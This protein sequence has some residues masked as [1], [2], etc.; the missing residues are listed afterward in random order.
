M[1]KKLLAGVASLAFIASPAAAVNF[2]LGDGTDTAPIA[3][4][5]D[6]KAGLQGQGLGLLRTFASLSISGPARVTF[7]YFGSESGFRN[8]FNV[9]G[10]TFTET[11]ATPFASRPMFT[12]DFPTVGS[13]D[14]Y[15]T[16]SGR[17]AT[18]LRP[19]TEEFGFFLPGNADGP[20]TPTTLWIGLDDQIQGDD[21]N[22]DDFLIRATISAIPEPAT[23]AMMIGGFGLVGA[24]MRRRGRTTVAYA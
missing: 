18:E 10:Q 7:E 13:F 23:W 17:G 2:I 5:N 11:N 22:H 24:A 16:S 1:V 12:I 19:G 14:P 15:F 4:N 3:S 21:D 6:F 9:G 20:L 8:T